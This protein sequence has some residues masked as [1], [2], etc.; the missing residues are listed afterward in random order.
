MITKLDTSDKERMNAIE[1]KRKAR[2]EYLKAKSVSK[3]AS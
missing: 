3:E 1:R 2:E